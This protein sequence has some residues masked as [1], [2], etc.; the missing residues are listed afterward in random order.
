MTD[1]SRRVLFFAVASIGGLGLLAALLLL[2]TRPPRPVAPSSPSV[3]ATPRIVATVDDEPILYSEWQQAVALDWLMNG[4][5]GQIAPSPEETLSRLINQ[6]LVLREARKSGIPKAD[7]VQ[8]EAWVA[9]FLASW[10]L[11]EAALDQALARADLTRSDLVGEVVPRLLQVEQAL[12]ELPP[13]GDSDAWVA[14]LRRRARVVLLENLAAPM[15]VGL[16]TPPANT[17]LSPTQPP[18]QPTPATPS[19]GIGPRVGDPAPDFSL[20]AVD[21][22]TLRLSDLHGQPVLLTFLATW[23]NPCLTELPMLQAVSDDDVTTLAIAVRE[24]QDVVSAFVNEAK[25]EIPVLLDQD[26]QVSDL[27][28]VHGLPTS[29]FLDRQGMILARHVGPL[30]QKTL[31][32]YLAHLLVP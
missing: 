21:G 15:P 2:F 9:S 18:P 27:Y 4:F 3:T 19:P 22:T 17:P 14:E 29:L 30:D 10:N 20:K 26:G 1:A 5:V 25:L 7:A 32:D 23:C 12:Q 13:D 6:H 28:Q 31:D 11:D 16:L 8:G 24:P